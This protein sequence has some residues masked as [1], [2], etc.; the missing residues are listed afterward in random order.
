[1]LP[2]FGMQAQTVPTVQ[3]PCTVENGDTIRLMQLAQVNITTELTFKNK[4][5]KEKYNKLKRDVKKV[6][7]FAILAS[8]K[9]REY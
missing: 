1:M 8:I 9:L 7:P 6:Y 2:A 3:V 4:K 5:E